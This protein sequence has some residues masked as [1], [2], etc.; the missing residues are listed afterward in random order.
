[1]GRRIGRL[2]VSQ[3]SG[4]KPTGRDHNPHAGCYWFAGGGSKGGTSYGE[5]DE[6]G[7]KAAVNKVDIHDIH[8]TILHLLGMDHKKLTYLHSGR[9]F[10]LTDVAGNVI[11]DI[12]A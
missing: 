10:R 12:V 11:N 1:M 2:P 3:L 4:G 5:T 6:I 7:H 8:A 9:R